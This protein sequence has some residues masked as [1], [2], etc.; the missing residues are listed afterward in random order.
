MPFL[1]GTVGQLA[2]FFAADDPRAEPERLFDC[3]DDFFLVFGPAHG[4]G[5]RDSLEVGAEGVQVHAERGHDAC[6][7]LDPLFRDA[8]VLVNVFSEP[9]NLHFL[10]FRDQNLA[11]FGARFRRFACGSVFEGG[12]QQDAAETPDIDGRLELVIHSL[13]RSNLRFLVLRLLFSK[14]P[15]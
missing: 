9:A 3:I 7:F 5:H 15:P 4:F 6:K 13:P 14:I 12:N 1:H 11:R 2:F 8:S 10:E